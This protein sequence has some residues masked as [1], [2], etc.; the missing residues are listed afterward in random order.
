MANLH[1]TLAFLGE[2]SNHRVERL[3]HSVDQYLQHRSLP[4]DALNLDQVGY[5][6]KPRIL[7]LGPAHWP[8]TLTHLAQQL[9][10]DV[11]R[12]SHA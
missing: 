5:W 2:I 6:P 8:D 11:D 4:G 9:V 7:W 10:T 3:C 1:I 12:G